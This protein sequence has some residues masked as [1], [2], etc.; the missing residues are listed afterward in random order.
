MSDIESEDVFVDTSSV[1]KN[2]LAKQ[3]HSL[4]GIDDCEGVIVDDLHEIP[5]II[6]MDDYIKD[7]DSPKNEVKIVKYINP[8]FQDSD[9]NTP[10]KKIDF[11]K[12]LNITLDRSASLLLLKHDI[13]ITKANLAILKSE[14]YP[15]LSLNYFNEYYHGFSRSGGASIGGSYYP[16]NSE[17]RNSL[18]LRA[19]YE[20][21]N[22]G[23]REIREALN[24][25]D[26]EILK[27]EIDLEKER[28]AKELLRNFTSALK[29]Q[30]IIK[31]KKRILAI[32]RTLL[33][34]TGRLYKAGLAS[35]ADISRL[36]VDMATVEK[37]ILKA[38]LDQVEALKNI[39]IL[40]NLKID[41]NSVSLEMLK[42][43]R[44]PK[45]GFEE[46]AKARNL[47]LQIDK[48][49]KEL[50]LYKKEYLPKLYANGSYQ[51]YGSDKDSFFDAVKEIERNNWNVGIALKWDIF[52][53][54]KTNALMEKK[55][56]EIERLTQEY[57]LEKIKF[58]ADRKKRE[59][60]GKMIDKIA[61]EEAVLQD[62]RAVQR[63]ILSR[64]QKAGDASILEVDRSEVAR[65]N[66]ELDFRLDVIDKVKEEI[67][68]ELLI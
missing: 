50:E 44:F 27:S 28:I 38:K 52:N 17:Y 42:L 26:V 39:E 56:V 48:K 47:K 6:K 12:L 54:F 34:N 29:A 19:D 61:T 23:D 59:L 46:S 8:K 62:E 18:N 32:K 57:K 11:W 67:L 15:T 45:R 22:F 1:K 65:L 63:D 36:R 4:Q 51:L 10:S 7:R 58:E 14:Y 66:S 49:I 40:S 16:A 41:P 9:L 21:L 53:G 33:N 5:T 60:I 35:R 30:E 55:K 2:E 13:K 37:S 43:N 68:S 3:N 64:L 24:D 25:I 31:I 20:I